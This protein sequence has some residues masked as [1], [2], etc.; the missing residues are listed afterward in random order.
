[1]HAS[2]LLLLWIKRVILR[3]DPRISEKS[4]R[5]I[6]TQRF[7]IPKRNVAIDRKSRKI[8]KKKR[9][10][11]I[12]LSKS[13]ESIKNHPKKKTMNTILFDLS[14]CFNIFKLQIA[15]VILKYLYFYKFVFLFV[16]IVITSKERLGQNKKKKQYKD[17]PACVL[18]MGNFVSSA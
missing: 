8:T 9:K 12:R 17:I 4:M 18:S 11:K 15:N 2:D 1:M 13:I 3:L 5:S 7:N 6:K 14:Q 10:Y 16:L